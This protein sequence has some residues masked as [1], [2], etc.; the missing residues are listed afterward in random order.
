[1]TG[2]HPE[3]GYLNF[4][5]L[6]MGIAGGC[7]IVLVFIILYFALQFEG[8]EIFILLPARSTMKHLR[9]NASPRDIAA[10]SYNQSNSIFSIML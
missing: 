10:V 5:L 2:L 9:M 7:L 8:E 6:I 4:I 1:M 3:E